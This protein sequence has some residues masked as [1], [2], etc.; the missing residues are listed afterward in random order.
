KRHRAYTLKW[1]GSEPGGAAYLGSLAVARAGN[2]KEFLAALDGWK[3]P[4][5]NFVYADVDGDIGWVAAAK[6]PVRP[7]HDG[8][9]PEPGVGGFEWSRYLSVSELPQRFNPKAG[10]VATAN[11]NILPEG[12]PHQ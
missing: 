6:T 1:V 3:I 5:L 9:L 7:R 4:G 11:H 10:F 2:R 8:L 12:Y